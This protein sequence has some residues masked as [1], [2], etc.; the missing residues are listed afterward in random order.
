MTAS[1]FFAG[2]DPPTAIVGGVEPDECHLGAG[3][4]TGHVDYSAGDFVSRSAYLE[5]E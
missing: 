1:S 4:R 2:Q 3:T 5:S